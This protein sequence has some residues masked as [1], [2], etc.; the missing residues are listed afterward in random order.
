MLFTDLN[1][2]WNRASTD[3]RIT[4]NKSRFKGRIAGKRYPWESGFYRKHTIFERLVA[5]F[6]VCSIPV[7]CI[8]KCDSNGRMKIIHRR[9]LAWV[10]TCSRTSRMISTLGKFELLVYNLWE[11]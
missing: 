10:H 9:V 7:P 3:G 1:L 11:M 6:S 5:S 4:I 8:V 2:S